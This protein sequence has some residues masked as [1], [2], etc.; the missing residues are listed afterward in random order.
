M[1]V[2]RPSF[3]K[4]RARCETTAALDPA[5]DQIIDEAPDRDQRF[6][7]RPE[8]RIGGERRQPAHAPGAPRQSC[9]RVAQGGRVA[10]LQPV[11]D[12]HDRGAARIAAE[13]RHGEER[14]QRIADAG[15]AVPVADE[16]RG[17]GQR[18]LAAL[19]A[20]ARG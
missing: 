7:L 4:R 17:G 9:D 8:A 3:S 2:T 15:A 6:G 1:S 18:L 20:A 14:L 16:M 13:P 5:V 12:D 19:A 10:A 11:G